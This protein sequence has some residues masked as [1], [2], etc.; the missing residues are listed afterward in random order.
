M[1]NIKVLGLAI[2]ASMIA[3]PVFAGETYVR[4]EYTKTD[5]YTKT[6][7]HLNSHT[8]SN[9]D[10]KYDAYAAKI[11]FGKTDDGSDNAHAIDY[12]DVSVHV[13]GSNLWGNYH[14]SNTTNVSGNINSF[15]K[16]SSFAHETSGGVR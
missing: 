1:K 9:R 12:Q 6:N 2:V 7:L 14:E 13:S 16:T 3:A 8:S 5:G 10:E 11:S 15:L 4:N